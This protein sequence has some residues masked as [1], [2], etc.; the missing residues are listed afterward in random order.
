LLTYD[1][2]ERAID[3]IRA[4]VGLDFP[5]HVNEAFELLRVVGLGL[6]FARHAEMGA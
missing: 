6:R 3:R 1:L 5:G 4:F 2:I